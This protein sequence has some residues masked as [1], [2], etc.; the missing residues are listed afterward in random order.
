MAM[1]NPRPLPLVSMGLPVYNGEPFLREALDSVLAQT[2]RDFD[3]AISDNG[4]T[5]R[6]Q[7]ICE[8]YAAR[9]PRIR[10]YRSPENR[11]LAWNYNRVFELTA[12]P[13]FK[14][15]A[16]DDV[17]APEYVERCVD[18]LERMPAVVLC[19]PQTIL[20]DEHGTRLR[21]YPDGC[22]LVSPR[23]SERLRDLMA[24]LKLSNPVF[25]VIRRSAL[26]AAPFG[27]YVASDIPLLAELAL[28]GEFYEIQE[29]LF[30]RRDH[31]QKS[32]R[33]NP[34]IDDLAALYDPRNRGKLHFVRWRLF[35]EHLASIRRVPMGAKEKL[36]CYVFMA[37]YFRWKWRDFGAD[38]RQAMGRLFKVS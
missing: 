17:C 29:R 6:T 33:A 20:I 31:P 5:D 11:G 26:P 23:P 37:K 9:D 10:Y 1:E 36:R 8:A 28:R 16:H 14:W 24:N 27:S 12:G 19:Y 2:Y 38:V 32:D 7:E 21:D 18:V 4:S 13:Y 30:Y 25:G 34:T 35:G 3:L 15:V 22:H